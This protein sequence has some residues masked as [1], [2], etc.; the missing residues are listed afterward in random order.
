MKKG[1]WSV[2]KLLGYVTLGIGAITLVNA[3]TEKTQAN[4]PEPVTETTTPY[5]HSRHVIT[6]TLNQ[7]EELKVTEGQ[8]INVGDI[9]SDRTSTRAKLQAKKE[10]LETAIAQAS[11]PLNQ[12][13]PVP[14]PTFQTELAALKQAQFNLN[15]ITREI[16]NFDKQ[17][18]F[19]DPFYSSVFESEK[20]QEL[21]NLKRRELE[22]S[23]N[24]EKAIARLD[25][26]KL[27]Y[28][29][30]QYEHSLKVSD[31]QTALQKQQEQVNSLQVQLDKV[32]DELETLVS[33]FSPYRGK[34]RRVKVLNHS[35]R[36]IN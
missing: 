13:K 25:E 3:N 4:Q 2:V 27:N 24:L 36:N 10:R 16:E 8:R 31:Y 7:L 19:K 29:K 30:Q 11:L 12:L 1:N 14:I 34:V 23:I 17:L 9:I 22:A 18:H 20:I 26:A 33:V 28:Q 5:S 6:L 35:D 21:A 32:N 15:V